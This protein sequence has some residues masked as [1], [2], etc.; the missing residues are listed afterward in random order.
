MANNVRIPRFHY[1]RVQTDA[2]EIRQ[3]SKNLSSLREAM[4]DYL[5]RR[6]GHFQEG[7]TANDIV[8]TIVETT[9]E[10]CEAEGKIT[11]SF[12]TQELEMI[13]SCMNEEE[14][15]AYLAT[16][17]ATFVACDARSISARLEAEVSLPTAEALS[18]D[19]AQIL[20]NPGEKSI[21][22][23]IDALADAISGDE[24][25]TFIYA[26]G[27]DALVDALRNESFVGENSGAAAADMLESSFTKAENYAICA[28]VC[29][30]QILDGKVAGVTVENADPQ[31]IAALVS[32]GMS[33]GTILKRLLRGEINRSM[34]MELLG[35]VELALKWILA[36]AYQVMVGFGIALGTLIL[37]EAFQVV[38]ILASFLFIAGL[39]LAIGT[40]IDSKE[41]GKLLGNFLVELTK[42]TIAL[43]IKLVKGIATFIRDR[44]ST[45]STALT[46]A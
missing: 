3:E 46:Q 42:A 30:G 17:E 23:R 34:A 6:S 2:N 16:L 41:D 24:M 35:K 8:D 40:A 21:A 15:Y 39:F 29:Y 19:I 11:A 12:L 1:E 7:K 22:E 25:K 10:Y 43:P 26:E 37:I 9:R 33:K 20:Q 13:I 45:S 32:A 5:N 28:C 18:A 27:N 4:L 38:G 31:I 36:K 44:V 14:A